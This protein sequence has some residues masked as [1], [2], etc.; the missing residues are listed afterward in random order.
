M[1]ELDSIYI[2]VNKFTMCG[3]AGLLL[4]KKELFYSLDGSQIIVD[5]IEK[6]CSRGSESFGVKEVIASHFGL[7]ILGLE[8]QMK[9]QYLISLI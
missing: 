9:A 7:L 4:T 5:M 8:P 6:I 3:L 2:L 1:S